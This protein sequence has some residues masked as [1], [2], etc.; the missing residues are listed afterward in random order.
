MVMQWTMLCFTAE[1]RENFRHA[2]AVMGDIIDVIRDMVNGCTGRISNTCY[3]NSRWKKC[4]DIEANSPSYA[5][6][7]PSWRT[8]F[9]CKCIW[10]A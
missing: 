8:G 7:E 5:G 2:S 4:R 1:V 3:E 10:G 9:D 6:G